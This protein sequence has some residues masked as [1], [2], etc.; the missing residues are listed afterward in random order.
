LEK[1]CDIILVTFIS[2]LMVMTYWN[3]VIIIFLMLDFVIISLK[4]HNLAKS[5]NFRSPI[6]KVQKRWGRKV[7][8]A[9]RFW[10]FVT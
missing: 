3:D 4:N 6:L 7:L 9:W 5:R 1:N 10:K 2:D 8:N